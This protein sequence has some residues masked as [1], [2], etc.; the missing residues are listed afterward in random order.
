MSGVLYTGGPGGAVAP[1]GRRSPGGA[2]TLAGGRG[3]GWRGGTG[4]RKGY[5]S[6]GDNLLLF[7][8]ISAKFLFLY[9][10]GDFLTLLYMYL[11]GY[12]S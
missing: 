4:G 12:F 5:N 1:A 3:P 7:P 2:V 10:R 6:R 9:P 8:G 11:R